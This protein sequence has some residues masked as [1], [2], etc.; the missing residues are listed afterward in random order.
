MHGFL[1]AVRTF[2][3]LKTFE[4][5]PIRTTFS[6]FS[7][8]QSHAF[9]CEHDTHDF[10]SLHYLLNSSNALSISASNPS[11]NVGVPHAPLLQS[12]STSISPANT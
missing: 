7:G 11:N 2:E 3:I 9:S 12:K 5:R 8:P 1:R 6:C 4:I 10:L